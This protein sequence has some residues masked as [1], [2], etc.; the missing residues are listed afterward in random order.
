MFTSSLLVFGLPEEWF[1]AND[2][3][4]LEL[5]LHLLQLRISSSSSLAED[6]YLFNRDQSFSHQF[7]HIS[8]Y[9]SV[10]Y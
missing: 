4:L 7:L 10:D 5:R 2:F 9:A 8:G 3:E 6:K 1:A